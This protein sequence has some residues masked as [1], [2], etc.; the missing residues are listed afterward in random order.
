MLKTLYETEFQ[1]RDA[2]EEGQF[3][4]AI[5]IAIE[6]K[7]AAT[8]YQH[9]NCVSDLMHKLVGSSKLIEQSLDLTLSAL[10]LN[11]DVDRYSCVQQAYSMLN[12]KEVSHA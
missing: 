5:R 7:E 6:A 8:K 1:L 3:P 2:V 4:L 9:F 11:F 12:Q 10:T